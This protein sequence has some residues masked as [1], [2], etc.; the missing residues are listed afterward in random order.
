MFSRVAP[1]YDFLNHF[2]SLGQDFRWRRAAARE[3]S[4]LE[5]NAPIADVCA[6]TGDLGFAFLNAAPQASVVAMDFTQEM[7]RLGA[8]KAQRRASSSRPQEGRGVFFVRGDALRLPLREGSCAAAGVAFGIRNVTDLDAGLREMFRI[9]KP[10]GKALILEFTKPSGCIFGPL[11]L[12]YFR[13]ILPLFGRV[14]SWRSGDAYSY[15]PASV[16]AFAGPQEMSDRM[17]A[18]GFTDVRAKALTFGT[19]HLYVGVRT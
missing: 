1:R 15:L 3:L 9:L 6:G 14:I 17:R 5:A 4:G 2:L 12:F 8:A 18:V 16:E 7:L 10:G 19:V 13:H 11:Y